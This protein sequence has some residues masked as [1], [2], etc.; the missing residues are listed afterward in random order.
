M[1]LTLGIIKLCLFQYRAARYFVVGQTVCH[2]QGYCGHSRPVSLNTSPNAGL[3]SSRP[4]NI[5]KSI[6][7]IIIITITWVDGFI[8]ALTCTICSPPMSFDRLAETGDQLTLMGNR[9]YNKGLSFFA[10][11][12][13]PLKRWILFC[14]SWKP[15]GFFNL[16][17]S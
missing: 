3:M 6:T 14:K 17:S 13:Y 1:L 4:F 9:L 16:N 2:H 15:K 11:P 12:Y 5:W 10:D 7:I 8:W